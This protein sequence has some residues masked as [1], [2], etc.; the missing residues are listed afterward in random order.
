MMNSDS[1]NTAGIQQLMKWIEMLFC[2]PFHGI[3]MC[4]LGAFVQ[5]LAWFWYS[6]TLLIHGDPP[7]EIYP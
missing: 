6:T 2:S 7:A 4:A 3:A 1:G 5:A